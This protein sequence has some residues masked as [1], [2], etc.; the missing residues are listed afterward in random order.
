MKLLNISHV[1]GLTEA[2]RVFGNLSREK[3]VRDFMVIHKGK[4]VK[5]SG[6]SIGIACAINFTNE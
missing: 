4:S 2:T 6:H 1:D 3:A 5:Y